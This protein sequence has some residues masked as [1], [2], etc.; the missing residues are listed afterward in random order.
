[1]GACGARTRFRPSVPSLRSGSDGPTIPTTDRRRGRHV[2]IDDLLAKVPLDQFAGQLGVDSPQAEGIARQAI[3][4][5]VGGMGANATDAGGATSLLG[6]LGEHAG[7]D[8]AE[9]TD[10]AKV[11][12]TDGNAIV[13]NIF[14]GKE[15]DVIGQLGGL[16][17]GDGDSLFAKA[18]PLLAPLVLRW[19]GGELLGNEPAATTG[20]S[21]IP[22]VIPG[23]QDDGG[24]IEDMLGGLLRGGGLGGL[25]GGGAA[26]GLGGLLAG[27]GG[28]ADLGG[29]LD[30][31]LG[32]GK[33]S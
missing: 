11:D 31:L 16:L 3:T 30:G 32:E 27:E 25:L 28:G 22:G 23:N 7:G 20:A 8:F 18:L 9:G 10:L 14:G 5:L 6:A 29:L 2:D 12:T 19:I 1:M 26:G 17:G 21:R 33:K 15:G 4:A 24:G 13:S